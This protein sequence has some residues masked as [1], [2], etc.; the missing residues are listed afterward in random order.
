MKTVF[1][2]K[3]HWSVATKPLDSLTPVTWVLQ[4]SG[5]GDRNAIKKCT[6]NETFHHNEVL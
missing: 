3:I 6:E 2:S 5:Q 4:S 1:G